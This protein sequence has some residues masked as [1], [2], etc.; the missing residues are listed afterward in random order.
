MEQRQVDPILQQD[1]LRSVLSFISTLSNVANDQSWDYLDGRAVS[2]PYQYQTV[3][4]TGYAI[5]G[6]TMSTSHAQPAQNNQ[7]ILLI[8]AAV[9]IF[10]LAK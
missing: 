4:N 7:A 5:E 9:A 6:T 8:I 1:A 2:Q 3:G 10:V